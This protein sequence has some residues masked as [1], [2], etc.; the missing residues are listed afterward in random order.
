MVFSIFPD[1]DECLSKGLLS[2]CKDP[3]FEHF[4]KYEGRADDIIFLDSA[5]KVSPL[6]IKARLQDYR[7]LKGA[8]VFGR[9][10]TKS[11]I[12]L[13]LKD[14]KVVVDALIEELWPVLDNTNA[15][16]PEH[17]QIHRDFI[18]IGTPKR[19]FQRAG[20]CTVV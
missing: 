9:V 18:V 20:K 5:L 15:L 14:P 7:V 16:V 12:L 3:G 6:Y 19:P 2:K 10:H 4:C 8:L 17:A 13:K 1:I 11:G